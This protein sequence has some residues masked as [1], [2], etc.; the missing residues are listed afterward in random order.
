M[1]FKKLLKEAAKVDTSTFKLGPKVKTKAQPYKANTGDLRTSS[2]AGS[3]KGGSLAPTGS[4]TGSLGLNSS[5]VEQISL[6]SNTSRSVSPQRL[7]QRPTSKSIDMGTLTNMKRLSP[8]RAVPSNKGLTT[9]SCSSLRSFSSAAKVSKSSSLPSS[10]KPFTST[11]LSVGTK[12]II[13]KSGSSAGKG[14][15]TKSRLRDSFRP[16]ELIPLA[17][18][19]KRDLR[20]IEEIQNDLWRKKGKQYPSVTGVDR[21]SNSRPSSTSP[22]PAKLPFNKVSSNTTTSKPTLSKS[23]PS[24]PISSSHPSKLAPA[25]SKAP[26]PHKRSRDSSLSSD[27]FIATEDEDE[28]LPEKFDYRAEIRSLFQRKGANS[29]VIDSDDDSDMEATGMEMEK[30][31][32]R[33]A[34][35]ARLEDEKEQRQLEERAREKKRR[36]LEMEKRV[37][38]VQK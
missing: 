19:P 7:T 29:R 5:K 32:A 4:K 8:S 3:A 38:G 35:L 16:N 23:T 36:K 15:D 13:S 26:L 11:K 30:E 17:Q 10:A 34:E 9:A 27:S 18:G 33:A 25:S 37:K 28:H 24:R 22:A 6:S 1:T 12:S 20:T 14:M 2:S 31:E 21:N